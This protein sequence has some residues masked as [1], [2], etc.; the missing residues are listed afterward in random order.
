MKGTGYEVYPDPYPKFNLFFRADNASLASLGIPSHTL[1]TT[2][3][4]VDPHYHKVDDEA[5]TLDVNVLTET[6]KAVAKGIETI[7]SGVDTPTRIL[8]KE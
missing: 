3:I 5:E 8:I 7:I 4:D 1:S 2:P 6:T